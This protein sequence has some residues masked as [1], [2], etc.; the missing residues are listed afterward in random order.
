MSDPLTDDPAGTP[1]PGGDPGG[2][3]PVAHPHGAPAP[4]D[5]TALAAVV[6]AVG[7]VVFGSFLGLFLPAFPAVIAVVSAALGHLALFRV[8]R[9]GRGGR[10]LALTAL[11]VSYVGLAVMAALV[12]GMLLFTGYAFAV[13]GF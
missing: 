2:D 6:L 9:S 13:L 5:S 12:L 4:V 7:N 11:A 8:R 10:V 3:G 1:G